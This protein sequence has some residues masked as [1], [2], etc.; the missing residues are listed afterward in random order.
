[1]GLAFIHVIEGQTGGARDLA[2]F[3]KGVQA[4]L[5]RRLRATG[6]WMVNNG[7]TR[8]M[9]M[10]PSTRGRP[11]WWPLARP[12]ISNPDLGAACATTRR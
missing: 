4:V 9:A 2:P 12:F 7:Y 8:E 1:M 11:T 10:A 6:A 3:D 5:L